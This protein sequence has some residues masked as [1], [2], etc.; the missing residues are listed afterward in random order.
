MSPPSATL[1]VAPTGNAVAV[2]IIG[3]A[4]CTV[5]PLFKEQ[6]GKLRARDS[7][8][9][10]IDLAQCTTM[11]STFLGVL[12]GLA[13]EMANGDP[14]PTSA[15]IELYQPNSRVVDLLENLGI[16]HFFHTLERLPEGLGGFSEVAPGGDAGSKRRMT[17]TSLAA[18][19]ALM[20]VNPENIPKFKDVTEFL[21]KD[22]T[23]GDE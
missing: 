10:I 23:R 6:A 16:A 2:R 4:N 15:V 8:H 17:A 5:S 22:L 19:E 14:A 21:A 12:A 18:H 11:D 13:L 20:R 3:R 7:K 9:L 1:F